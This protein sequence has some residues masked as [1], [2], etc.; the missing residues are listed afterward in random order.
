M[1]W[2]AGRFALVLLAGAAVASCASLG[3][4]VATSDTYQLAVPATVN[5]SSVRR[6]LQLLVPE[7]TA[8]KALDSENIVIKPDAITLQYL[9][10]S[11][12]SDRL[13][14]LVQQ[15]LAEAFEG[16]QRFDGVGLPGQGLA[17]DYQLVTDIRAFGVE[18]AA[19]QAVIVIGAKLLNDRNGSVRASRTFRAVASVGAGAGAPQYVAALNQAFGLAVQDI[20]L[21]TTN[22]L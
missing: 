3:P 21:W 18:I 8:L 14:R 20:V 2:K 10:E 9:D 7:P 19:G 6:G 16:T 11:Q 15:R 12:W 13:P 5:A 17:I 22:R 4:Q 1:S